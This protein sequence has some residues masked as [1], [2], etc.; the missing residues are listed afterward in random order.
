LPSL[1]AWPSL[2]EPG[3]PPATV[4]ARRQPDKSLNDVVPNPSVADEYANIA[5]RDALPPQFTGRCRRRARRAPYPPRAGLQ[6]R[7]FVSYHPDPH[8]SCVQQK[9]L[10]Q[11]HL[12][13]RLSWRRNC[14]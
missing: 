14:P 3:P 4:A 13:T 5:G 2:A 6:L 9:P 12:L 7:K 8:A 1:E 11:C 10:P